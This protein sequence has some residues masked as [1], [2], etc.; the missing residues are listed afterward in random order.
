MKRICLFQIVVLFYLICEANTN[1]DDIFIGEEFDAGYI[2]ISE[3]KNYCIDV[4]QQ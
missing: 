4:F 3:T 1:D 2:G